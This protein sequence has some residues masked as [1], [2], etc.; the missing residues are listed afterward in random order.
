MKLLRPLHRPSA[1]FYRACCPLFN[2]PQPPFRPH[3]LRL[4]LSASRYIIRIYG[5]LN[6][7]GY[8]WDLRFRRR[9]Q[10]R[11]H[12]QV[13]WLFLRSLIRSLLFPPFLRFALR[14]FWARFRLHWPYKLVPH[15]SQPLPYLFQYHLFAKKRLLL[16]RDTLPSLISWFW[17][18]LAAILLTWRIYCRP[19]FARGI[20]NPK[21]FWRV[22]W[23]CRLPNAVWLK[24]RTSSPGQKHF[25]FIKWFCA[26]IIP[27][28][29]RTYRAI[30]C[31][32]FR[33]LVN[34]QVRHSLTTTWPS[35][36]MRQHQ[37]LPI[38]QKWIRISTIFICGLLKP[39]LLARWFKPRQR[40]VVQEMETRHHLPVTATLGM[41]VNV[42][43]GWADVVFATPAC[44]AMGNTPK[45]TA[46]INPTS[47]SARAPP[48][49]QGREV[50]PNALQP[51]F[52]H[53][54]NS[55][56]RPSLCS[57]SV[58]GAVPV[59]FG[60]SVGHGL[61]PVVV[62]PSLVSPLRPVEF[63]SPLIVS[64]FQIELCNHPDRAA[65]SYVLEGLKHGFRLG[66]SPSSWV[67]KSSCTNMRSAIQQPSV[68]D[69]Y[70][71][72]EIAHG[73]IAGPF[74]TSPFPYLHISRFGVIPKNNQPGKWRLIL[75]LSS[76][77]GHSVNDG[78][79]RLPYSVQY[80]T[81]DEFID[82][83]MI[84][85]QGALMA[86]F[87]VATAYRNIAVHPDDRY[88]LGMKWRGAYY[89]DMA[90]PFG[91]RSAPFIFTSVADMVEWTLTHNHGV[92]FL[93][94]YLDDF[95]TLGP[96]ASDVCLT[97]LATCLQLC[98]DL[99][100]PL[101]PDKLEGPTTCL[102]I[103]GIELDSVK[104]Q[105]RLPAKKRTDVIALLEV[106]SRK[107]FCRRKELESLIGHLRHACKIAPQGRTFLRRMINLLCAFQRDDH[108]IRLNREF[109]L[110]LLWWQELFRV[111]DGL[112]LFLTPT[113]AP[114]PDFQVSSDAAGSLGYGAI[115]QCHW[116]SG[117]WSASQAPL[118]IAYKEL[119]PVVVAAHLWGP[120]W[121]SRRVEFLCDN[122]AV[123]SV[124]KS[125]TS[126]D[127]HLMRYCVIFLCWLCVTRSPSHLLLFRVGTTR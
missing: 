122:E 42:V 91:L 67:L 120:S 81:I 80:V 54:V 96:P 105:A 99:G 65:V 19:I 53:S 116:F 107:Q 32:L 104:L 119:F 10:A 55:S 59:A 97:N 94:H 50:G 33:R 35:V 57:V 86:K 79:P 30:N 123:V 40:Q 26:I 4:A 1:R 117:S 63:V 110:D 47:S 51:R 108:P 61:P 44:D 28:G 89:V 112:S 25:Q 39:R 118:S 71:Q 8:L 72:T 74:P 93:R 17:K 101:H 60:S 78:I 56:V 36:R 103:L 31:W 13:G 84:R 126:R 85:G 16:V 77:P 27:T 24:C 82:G 98:S 43:G 95:L 100:L 66:F 88:L 20:T 41:R 23:W 69:D 34:T 12:R 7:R 68:I 102:T 70:L 49:Q 45:S 62:S 38:G 9:P 113:W 87:D 58:Q 76:S 2:Q 125:G 18:S 124:L 29:G 83:I 75:D 109:R 14:H 111:W 127:P 6:I 21:H 73:R 11:S 22:N 64:K 114:I 92:D 121:A 106:W 5:F 3:L 115:F 15:S 46:L 37:A 90:L 48:P 52:V